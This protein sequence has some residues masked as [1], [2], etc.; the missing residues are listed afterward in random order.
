MATIEIGQMAEK[1]VKRMGFSRIHVL[2][3]VTQTLGKVR[4][5]WKFEEKNGNKERVGQK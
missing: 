2:V 3:I 1:G 4:G 5:W